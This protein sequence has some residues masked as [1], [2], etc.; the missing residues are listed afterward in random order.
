MSMSGWDLAIEGYGGR[1]VGDGMG[2][3]PYPFNDIA[4]VEPHGDRGGCMGTSPYDSKGSDTDP[5][6]YA[7][8][9]DNEDF[10]EHR[11]GLIGPAKPGSF[12]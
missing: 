10:N 3:T 2:E 6:L 12:K 11:S 4:D 5:I 9:H 1:G 8:R 7:D